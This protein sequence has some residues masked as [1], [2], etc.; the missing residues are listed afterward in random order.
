PRGRRGGSEAGG[1]GRGRAASRP[2]ALPHV[3]GTAEGGAFWRRT[4]DQK[5]GEFAE[6]EGGAFDKDDLVEAVFTV[7]GEWYSGQIMKYVGDGSW[8]VMWLDDLPEG[9]EEIKASTVVGKN[10]RHM[11]YT[12]VESAE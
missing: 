1:G 8:I 6:G 5:W 4:T 10:I 11:S 9:S 7:D 3:R 12:P 2:G